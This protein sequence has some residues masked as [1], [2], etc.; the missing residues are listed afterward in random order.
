MA[1]MYNADAD[2]PARPDR[3]SDDASQRKNHLMALG[4]QVDKAGG[5]S[6]FPRV[7]R[8]PLGAVLTILVLIAVVTLIGVPLFVPR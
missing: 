8:S 4:D 6:P 5:G 3:H 1:R 7:L 2:E